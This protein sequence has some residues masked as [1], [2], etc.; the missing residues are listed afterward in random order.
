M[1]CACKMPNRMPESSIHGHPI[2]PF[3]IDI[4]YLPFKR[5]RCFLGPRTMV[6]NQMLGTPR[7]PQQMIK[8]GAN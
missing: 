6:A 8:R 2:V 3:A 5:L 4:L 1:S 7:S